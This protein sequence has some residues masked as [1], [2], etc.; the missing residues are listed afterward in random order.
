MI[1]QR[2]VKW[3][4]RIITF[5]AVL[6]FFPHVPFFGRRLNLWMIVIVFMIVWVPV[7]IVIKRL[8]PAPAW[9]AHEDEHA[10]ITS[11]NLT[12]TKIDKELSREEISD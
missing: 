6:I 9:Y 5:I 10:K 4:M 2:A 7:E 11:L 1:H 3:L 8:F 12:Q